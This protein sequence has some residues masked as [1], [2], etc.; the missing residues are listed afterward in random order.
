MRVSTSSLMTS[1][2]ARA[3][4]R[5]KPEVVR[6]TSCLIMV[7]GRSLA[8]LGGRIFLDTSGIVHLFFPAIFAKIGANV[9][10]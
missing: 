2:Q 9:F 1:F 4:T 6:V 5:P 3:A 8:S 10:G 7:M